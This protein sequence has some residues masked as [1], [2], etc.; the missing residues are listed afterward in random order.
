MKIAVG[1]SI[2]NLLGGGSFDWT[3]WLIRVFVLLLSI[4]IHEYSH[5]RMAYRLGDDTAKSQG[6]LTL[7]PLVH[8]DPIGG[9]LILAGAPVAWAKPV[10]VNPARFDRG[11]TVKK[12]M[13]LTAIAGPSSNIVL[14]IISYFLYSV[15][16]VVVYVNRLAVNGVGMQIVMILLQLFATL[17]ITNVFLAIFNLLPVPPLD[18]SRVLGMILPD[19]AYYTVMRYERTIGIAFILLIILRPQWLSAAL[20]LISFPIRWVIT[21]PLDALAAWAVSLF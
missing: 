20:N 4:S 5:A 21:K 8:F 6:R 15:M 14:A 9:L 1:A 10:P 12:G 2:M 19:K 11:V 18:G 3:A 17:Y 13:M 7:N 16:S